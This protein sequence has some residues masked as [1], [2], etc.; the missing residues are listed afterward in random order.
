MERI[1][2][3]QTTWHVINIKARTNQNTEH[4]VRTFRALQEEDPLIELPR[5]KCESL[6][7]I[8]FSEELENDS[9]NKWIN[10]TLLSY[11]MIDPEAFYDRRNRQD[12]NFEDWNKD[13]VANK[14]EAE[15]IFIPSVHTMVVKRNSA[16]S[17]KNIIL[18][19][20]EALNRI[21]PETFDISIVVERDILDRILNAH[22]VC[23]IEANLSYSNPG[24]TDGFIAAFDD[25]LRNMQPNEFTIMAKGSKEHPLVNEED[26]LLQS[27]VNLSER[28]GALKAI[29]QPTE[30]SKLETI[31]TKDHPRILVIPQTI[32]NIYSTLYNTISTIFR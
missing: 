22:A 8:T 23:A 27:I 26:G 28:D 32:N 12:V 19:L 15:L 14:K 7:S 11:T 10:M 6:K 4:Y 20:N 18:Y 30:G 3:K 29:I 9:N 31:E 25:K 17:L 2:N 5:E 24:H 1:S 21:E 13:I 16:I